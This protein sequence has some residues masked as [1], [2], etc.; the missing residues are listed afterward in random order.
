MYRKEFSCFLT[1]P[2][3]S[4]TNSIKTSGSLM[5]IYIW[6]SSTSLLL[7][8][9][10]YFHL[11]ALVTL[12][13]LIGYDTTWS[14]A[15]FMYVNWLVTGR[16]IPFY[17]LSDCTCTHT[18]VTTYNTHQSSE[19]FIPIFTAHTDIIVCECECVCV[20]VREREGKKWNVC[21]CQ[22]YKIMAFPGKYFNYVIT[23]N[24]NYVHTPHKPRSVRRL[25]FGSIC[26]HN[27]LLIA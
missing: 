10:V 13:K 15:L 18:F 6:I 1:P 5:L 7:I 8:L 27:V 23:Q 3:T 12:V 4:S 16:L 21:L 17:T 2:G 24:E 25:I 20:C 19:S 14:I 11:V 26:C 9:F 22:F